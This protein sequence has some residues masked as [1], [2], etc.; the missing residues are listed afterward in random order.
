MNKDKESMDAKNCPISIDGWIIFLSGKLNEQQHTEFS[1]I[2][3]PIIVVSVAYTTFMISSLGTQAEN[4]F[5]SRYSFLVFIG[6]LVLLFIE[7]GIFFW[8]ENK[9][10]VKK[11]MYNKILEKIINGDLTESNAIR[12]EW[13]AQKMSISSTNKTRISSIEERIS[14][15][16]NKVEK[17]SDRME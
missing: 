6:L 15:I 14:K 1:E 7:A 8:K 12:K 4:L 11:E 16:E 5:F 13:L 9:T 3:A 17:I 10:S 2:S